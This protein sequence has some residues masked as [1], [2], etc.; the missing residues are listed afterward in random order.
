MPLEKVLGR[1]ISLIAW[2]HCQWLSVERVIMSAVLEFLLNAATD[3]YSMIQRHSQVS[4]I[5]QIMKVGA[6]EYAIIGKMW[7][8]LTEGLDVRCFQ[9]WQRPLASDGAP[10]LVYVSHRDPK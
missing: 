9:C 1:F 5:K 3:F 6:E 4:L 8:K 2:K 7:P 10:S